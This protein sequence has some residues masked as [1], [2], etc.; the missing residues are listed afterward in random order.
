LP[1]SFL[2]PDDPDLSFAAIRALD[3]KA[4]LHVGHIEQLGVYGYKDRDPRMRV[5]SSAWVAFAPDLGGPVAGKN[6]RVAEWVP[7]EDIKGVRVMAFDHD[8]IVRDAVHR[9][10]NKLEY[11][12][13]AT[14]FLPETFTIGEL[15]RVYATVWGKAPDAGNFYRKV[16]VSK[17]FLTKVG[18]IGRADLFR[19]GPAR[20]L[21]PPIRREGGEWG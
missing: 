10:R 13:L 18:Q 19:A 16:K 4:K 6:V 14:S 20:M 5:V 1:G 11:T 12:T 21:Y 8:Q 15:R 9:A 17:G 7:Y 2:R 3:A